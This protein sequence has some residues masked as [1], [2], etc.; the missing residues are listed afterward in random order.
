[1]TTQGNRELLEIVRDNLKIVLTSS[2]KA[3]EKGYE[4]TGKFYAAT[5]L[6]RTSIEIYDIAVFKSAAAVTSTI[7]RLR[8]NI[9]Y[10]ENYPGDIAN[11]D[12]VHTQYDWVQYHYSFFLANFVSI[13]DLLLI[14]INSI[15]NLG[16]PQ[17]NCKRHIILKNAWVKETNIPQKMDEVE[18]IVK[19]YRESRNILIHQ[20]KMPD[21]PQ[22]SE[23]S[24]LHYLSFYNI[25]IKVK[26]DFMSSDL[27]TKAWEHELPKIKYF[28]LS[29]V[30][31]IDEAVRSM[32]E[33]LLPYYLAVREKYMHENDT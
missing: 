13:P 3:I 18:S 26:N 4:E 25:P 17:R 33:A 22:N 32:F 2:L 7:D 9:K 29:K 11:N 24:I 28:L 27:L 19:P 31:R 12:S 14:T 30:G 23:G 21:M 5:P 10:L 8:Q 16:N 1:M 20:G 6:E 15:F